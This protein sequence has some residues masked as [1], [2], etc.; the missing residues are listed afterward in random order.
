MSEPF[1]AE[2]RMVGFNFAPHGRTP[3]EDGG[4]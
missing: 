3:P 1:L 4:A 2:V